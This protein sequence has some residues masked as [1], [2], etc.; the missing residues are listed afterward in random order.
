[1]DYAL[2][3]HT[4]RC[5]KF[6]QKIY[7]NENNNEDYVGKCQLSNKSLLETLHRYTEIH[8]A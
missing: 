6:A 3:F 8:F 5:Y 7:T 4:C 1:M 2:E